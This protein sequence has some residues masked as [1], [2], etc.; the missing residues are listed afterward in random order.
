MEENIAQLF[1]NLKT[2]SVIFGHLPK[3]CRTK[4]HSQK[5]T[6]KASKNTHRLTGEPR[7]QGGSSEY[8]MCHS[9]SIDTKPYMVTVKVNG[10]DL[11]MEQGQLYL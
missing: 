10:A 11:K 7:E 4:A 9:T 8:S 1:A 5:P 6:Q 3:V 2:V